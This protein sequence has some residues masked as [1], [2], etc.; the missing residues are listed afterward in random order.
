MSG[1]ARCHFTITMTHGFCSC[2]WWCCGGE[3]DQWGVQDLEEEYPFPLR[4]GHDS[5]PRVAQPHR[6]VAAWCHK[7]RGDLLHPDRP[8][9]YTWDGSDLKKM[10]YI[11]ILTGQKGK[12][13]VCTDSSWG[14]ILLM[15]RIIL[16]SLVFSSRMMT[17]SLMPHTTTVRKEVRD[18][19]CCADCSK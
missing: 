14:H 18:N 10:N 9:H 11:S 8:I 15:S 13:T 17:P 7:V 2:V 4:P 3:G 12:T 5:R 16:W 6:P 1:V 19:I